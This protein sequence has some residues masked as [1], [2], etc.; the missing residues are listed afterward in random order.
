MTIFGNGN[1]QW[2]RLLMLCV[3]TVSYSILVNGEPKGMIHPTRGIHQGD[4]LSSFRF[5]LCTEGLH[6]L[7]NQVSTMG[8]IQGYSLCRNSPKLTHILFAYDS[9]LFCRATM[10]ECQKILDILRSMVNVPVSR[11][12][13]T[14][15]P[16][17]SASQPQRI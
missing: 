14:K 9:L 4:P 11:S 2:E 15:L 3:T 10:Q 8:E 17:S 13:R 6:G 7:L 1:E 12:I 5:L 16:S